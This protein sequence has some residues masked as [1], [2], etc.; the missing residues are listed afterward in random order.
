MIVCPWDRT[1][2]HEFGCQEPERG[3]QIIAQSRS[4]LE[5]TAC[6]TDRLVRL[7]TALTTLRTNLNTVILPT[8]PWL[9]T[10]FSSDQPGYATNVSLLDI[11]TPASQL[12]MTSHPS[13]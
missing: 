7:N 9:T 8:S 4:W 2:D 12:G 10:P 5:H 6:T 1:A 13:K 11:A 3:G